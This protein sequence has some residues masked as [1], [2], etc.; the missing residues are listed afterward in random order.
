MHSCPSR[1]L[2]EEFL[3]K[4]LDA[5]RGKDVAAHI[6]GC[7]ACQRA[8][9]LLTSDPLGFGEAEPDLRSL[10]QKPS[11]IEPRQGPSV[12]GQTP[13]DADEASSF[14]PDA[15]LLRHP[16]AR[17]S[18]DTTE[19]GLSPSDSV[20]ARITAQWPMFPDYE[21]LGVLG[22]GAMGIVYK[23]RQISLNRMVA[24][25]V[26]L[27][28]SGA[29]ESGLRRFRT[30]AEALARL[31]HANIVQVFA[32]GEHNGLPYLALELVEG[33][34][35]SRRLNNTPQRPIHAAA[36]VEA[37]ARAIHLAHEHDIVHRDLKPSNILLKFRS[38]GTTPGGRTTPSDSKN[39]RKRADSPTAIE[40]PAPEKS[41]SAT[42]LEIADYGVPKIADFGLAR[43]VDSTT[44]L[45]RTGDLMG[46]PCYIAPEQAMAASETSR[47]ASGAGAAADIY[48]LG[49]ILYEMLT[50]RP[51]F[52]ADTAVKTLLMVMYQDPISP[53]QL[54][55]KVPTDLATICL[56]CLEK[57]PSRRYDTAL[58]L[59]EDLHRF[60]CGL[61]I[62]A[63]R[64][65]TVALAWRW[66]RRRPLLTAMGI[67]LLTSLAAGFVG[68]TI[69]WFRAGFQRQLAQTNAEDAQSSLYFSRIAQ[70]QLEWRLNNPSATT[71]LL[72]R[73]IPR[74][75]EPDR[76]GWEWYYL[77]N[78]T[79]ADVAVLSRQP[80][81]ALQLASLR[82]SPDG[83]TLYVGGGAQFERSERGGSLTVWNLRPWENG[84]D[85]Q[86]VPN[87]GAE[88]NLVTSVSTDRSGRICAF[89]ESDGSIKIWDVGT[90]WKPRAL[91]A[92][93]SPIVNVAVSPDGTR[94]AASDRHGRVTVSDTRTGEIVLRLDGS[95]VQ[96]SVDGKFVLT[97]GK[98]G[99]NPLR[100]LIAWDSSTG[101]A[102]RTLHVIAAGFGFSAD[103]SSLVTWNGT[104]V[105]VI[106]WAKGQ[107][108]A[109]FASHEGDIFEATFSPDVMH[110]ATAGADRTVRL[111]D[112]RTGLEELVFRGHTDRIQSVAFHPNGRYLASADQTS[113]RVKIWDLTR[114]PDYAA[115]SGEPTIPRDVRRP[116]V[117][118]VTLAL[119]FNS[120]NRT[121]LEIRKDGT[122]R[123]HDA[124]GGLSS[125]PV[126]E[127]PVD[128]R[129]LTPSTRAMFSPDNR[130]LAAVDSTDDRF[131]DL[132]DS[133]SCKR[134]ARFESRFPVFRIAFSR[135]GKRMVTAGFDWK[136][137]G[138]QREV[139]VWDVA[140]GRLIAQRRPVGMDGQKFR[141]LY[142]VA[143]LSPDGG[144]VAYDDYA[145]MM[146]TRIKIDD[147]ASGDGV[148]FA[149]GV[150]GPL[151]A[152]EF[153]SD[154]RM[155]ATGSGDGLIV[156]HDLAYGRPV[157][158]RS[159]EGPSASMGVLA[160][161]P[162][163]RLLAAVDR[164]QVQLWN[165]RS[166]HRVLVLR[167]APPRRGDNG[168]NARAAWSPDGRF[169]TALN[170]DNTVTTWDA[171]PALSKRM[172][173]ADAE[174]RAFAWH[175]AHAQAAVWNP[176][177]KTGA[178]FHL[179]ALAN[180]KPP[181]PD[182]R[183]ERSV[184]YAWLGRWK[185]AANEFAD[186]PPTLPTPLAH[187]AYLEALTRLQ[188]DDIAGWHR[189]LASARDRF[190]ETAERDTAAYLAHMGLLAP[191]GVADPIQFARWCETAVKTSAYENERP[192]LF[193]A[194]SY[195]RG[196]FR[197]AAQ[198]LE[199][200]A[201]TE[202]PVP[203]AW[204]FLAMSYA[205]LE[206]PDRARHWYERLERWAKIREPTPSDTV[207][208]VI[209]PSIDWDNTQNW[210]EARLLLREASAVL[211][212]PKSAKPGP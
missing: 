41:S 132:W 192:M 54:Q 199:Q 122:L 196:Q 203:L 56:K 175:L 73:C 82:F 177:L 202:R 88:S 30:E 150:N 99:Q 149:S 120:D 207:T 32:I 137:T 43:L 209:P 200:A 170:H 187:W 25:K 201:Q 155:L 47:P 111:W 114:H 174:T 133:F 94:V 28:G 36:L 63:R 44:R 197:E 17:T 105:R 72:E 130:W 31:Q 147:L 22:Q 12:P 148:V 21:I 93:T 101:Q 117:R 98:L 103:G 126:R 42:G 190:G 18:R 138:R 211:G 6:D 188:V 79:H 183:L 131:V 97:G 178:Q 9:D 118:F 7:R 5:E 102:I 107:V 69:L 40:Q 153:S 90:V 106:D 67:A 2:L 92:H 51:P 210:M 55:P 14:D 123:Q 116:L 195:R 104:E 181:N 108:T 57:E 140:S 26:V 159:M 61:P 8:L 121:L 109:T 128:A 112:A 206:Q 179:R 184:L 194:T 100:E 68:M 24:L 95:Y 1:E 185:D 169:L 38:G 66:C 113:G 81:G 115:T 3:A 46:T 124:R 167:G 157:G 144:R 33:E 125:T 58:A 193:G 204:A 182:L 78:L 163:D 212:T 64:T 135:N 176:A 11:G 136:K 65:G 49:A 89:G 189:V 62:L 29:P 35:L 50:G 19:G 129:W 146:P 86:V 87:V 91:Q 119:G 45:T 198:Q 152:L 77:N 171:T 4:T 76:R 10:W 80:G 74:I 139:K 53:S 127:I 162:D 83:H 172:Q 156:V 20:N 166:G 52:E 60:S 23:A 180:L 48:A 70:A 34:T 141:G 208:V 15:T 84:E 110:I 27:A 165:V 16:S 145:E 191:D 134:V 143:A 168:F 71:S 39:R 173:H 37:L 164:E 160:F 186:P 13:R 59:A 96:F 158:S 142:G 161:S 205:R 154:A 75:N 85:P 151:S